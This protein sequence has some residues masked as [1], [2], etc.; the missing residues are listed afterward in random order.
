MPIIRASDLLGSSLSLPSQPHT[1]PI[2]PSHSR[3]FPRLRSA[4][5]GH[6]ILV[7]AAN[8]LGSVPL[9]SPEHVEDSLHVCFHGCGLLPDQCPSRRYSTRRS[10]RPGAGTAQPLAK[11]MQ[12]CTRI[13]SHGLLSPCHCPQ[14]DEGLFVHLWHQP[15]SLCYHSARL[16]YH[17]WLLLGPFPL[18]W[19]PETVPRHT[20]QATCQIKRALI[21]TTRP[22]ARGEHHWQYM[23]PR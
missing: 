19:T 12:A 10:R 5:A 7:A 16:E 14:V 9:L 22:A 18:D 1:N 3:L 23:H 8:F 17:D 11:P 2:T 21:V 15:L 20:R 4:D 6:P 13:P